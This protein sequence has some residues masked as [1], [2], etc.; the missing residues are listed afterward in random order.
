MA[1]D[2]RLNIKVTSAEKSAIKRNAA[3]FGVAFGLEDMDVSVV[4]RHIFL[5]MN[6]RELLKIICQQP[7]EAQPA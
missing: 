2:V 4:T 5:N 1:R 3:L 7:K 6:Q